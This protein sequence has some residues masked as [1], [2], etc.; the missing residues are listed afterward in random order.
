MLIK[1]NRSANRCF[2]ILFI[3]K[4]V[5]VNC[6]Q[7][8]IF[9]CISTV[10]QSS[11]CIMQ[12]TIREENI[13]IWLSIT[14]TYFYYTLY[15]NHLYKAMCFI[16][17]DFLLIDASLNC[18]G[19]KKI[20]RLFLKKIKAHDLVKKVSMHISVLI[21]YWIKLVSTVNLAYTIYTSPFLLKK[22]MKVF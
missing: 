13:K 6:F 12:Q 20:M 17:Q 2:T 19:N 10:V 4:N 15:D 14:N 8:F 18:L 7:L 22:R 5:I 21:A 11:V 3:R 16:Y 9:L 1:I